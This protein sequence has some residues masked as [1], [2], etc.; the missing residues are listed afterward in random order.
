M[1]AHVK[2]LIHE[3]LINLN[4][5]PLSDINHCGCN[6]HIYTEN[7]QLEDCTA[8]RPSD[9]SQKHKTVDLFH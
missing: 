6:Y 7:T 9:C 1:A 8:Q 3:V 2:V 4:T 5:Q